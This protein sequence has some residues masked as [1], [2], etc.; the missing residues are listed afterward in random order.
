M[1]DGTGV[2]CSIQREHQML[3]LSSSQNHAKVTWKFQYFSLKY[4]EKKNTLGKMEQQF[5]GYMA[6]CQSLVFQPYTYYGEVTKNVSLHRFER[7]PDKGTLKITNKQYDYACRNF[8]GI[9]KS[10]VEDLGKIFIDQY[11]NLTFVNLETSRLL[12][13]AKL[14]RFCCQKGW[15]STAVWKALLAYLRFKLCWTTRPLTTRVSGLWQVWSLK[16]Q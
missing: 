13:L 3:Q 6:A 8:E 1:L 12:K 15:T 10:L 11:V 14:W 9:T 5:L 16:H 2:P 7:V 4:S